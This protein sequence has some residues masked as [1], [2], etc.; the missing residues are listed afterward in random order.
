M[1]EMRTFVFAIVFIVIFSTLLISI[2]ADLQG[3][4]GTPST[5]VPVNPNVGTDFTASETFQKSDFIDSIY[6]WYPATLG[7]YDFECMFVANTFYLA[8]KAKFF[9][10]W[11][12]AMNSISFKY[13]NGS[14]ADSVSLTDIGNNAVDGVITFSLISIV[15]GNS[16]G[17]FLFYWN[18]TTYANDPSAAWTGNG[19]Y[20]LHGVGIT[21]NTDIVSLLLS[22][23]FL[24]LPDCPLLINI[25]LATPLWAC[26]VF[27]FWFII[28][29]SLPFV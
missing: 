17:T 22:L 28:K 16:A 29:E 2:P 12:G 27:L 13:E 6:Y 5:I 15:D 9:G 10:V 1:A 23:L 3:S 21:A 19:L 7:G 25:L 26:I 24:Q 18:T 8:Y 4:G 11:L 20:L 14:I